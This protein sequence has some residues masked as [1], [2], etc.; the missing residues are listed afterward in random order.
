MRPGDRRRR[1]VRRPHLGRAA[2]R[3]VGPDGLKLK[4][5]PIF[6]R[7]VLPFRSFVCE[8]MQHGRLFL[9]GDAAHTVPP[10]GAKGL[11][12]A[13]ADVSVLDRALERA[14]ADGR[15][16]ARRLH[17]AALRAGLAGA[18]LLLVDDLDAAHASRRHR[19]RPA[20]PGGRAGA[21]TGSDAGRTY[22][23]EAYTGWPGGR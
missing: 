9:A 23:A 10:T 14:T 7:D 16:P 15:R 22:L 19:L 6:Q 18:A 20:P 1:L 13:I 21:V 8:P 2:A 12:L 3:V 5:G 17:R 11:N 4:E